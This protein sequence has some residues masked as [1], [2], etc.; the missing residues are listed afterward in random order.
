MNNAIS[1][2]NILGGD[3]EYIWRTCCFK[4]VP[5]SRLE[6]TKIHSQQEMEALGNFELFR[7]S[8]SHAT[9]W[10]TAGEREV[11]I[12]GRQLFDG[13]IRTMVHNQHNGARRDVVYAQLKP[14]YRTVKQNAMQ[15]M[16]RKFERTDQCTR[17]TEE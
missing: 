17:K 5:F 16:S 8:I 9:A 13:M 1:S 7:N 2:L 6:L 10:A 14:E 3:V 4:G 11:L 15:H 12:G